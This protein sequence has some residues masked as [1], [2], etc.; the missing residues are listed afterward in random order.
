MNKNIKY[1]EY[2]IK[3][4][5]TLSGLIFKMYGYGMNDRRY[6]ESQEHILMLNPHIT[7]PDFIKA[8]NILWLIALPPVSKSKSENTKNT[9]TKA[10]TVVQKKT[11]PQKTKNPKSILKSVPSQDIESFRCLAWLEHNSAVFTTPV[12]VALNTV[13]NMLSPGN[14]GLVKNFN[15]HHANYASGKITKVQR[16]ALLKNTR[17]Q[18]RKNFGSLNNLFFGKNNLQ[19]HRIANGGGIPI[20]THLEMQEKKLKRLAKL[21][22]KGGIVLSVVGVGLACRDIARATT[23]REKNG[24]FVETIISTAAGSAIGFSVGV[25]LFFNPVTLVTALVLA[26]GAAAVSYAA[27]KGLRNAYDKNE[28]PIDFVTGLGV[29]KICQ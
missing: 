21:A 25:F 2:K 20:T 27:G 19:N 6:T 15:Q 28:N 17:G 16:D 22:Q 9:E 11:P 18:L 29:T 23:N 14:M 4:G 26:T 3:A 5:D 7:N 12:A 10:K 13:E 24:I 1:F 8:G